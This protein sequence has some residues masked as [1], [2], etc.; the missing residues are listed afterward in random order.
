MIKNIIIEF[1]DDLMVGPDLTEEEWQQLLQG[2][3]EA[4]IE[5]L[6]ITSVIDERYADIERAACGLFWHTDVVGR[7]Q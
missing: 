7:V 6:R 4:A 1:G 5:Q 3:R 2:H